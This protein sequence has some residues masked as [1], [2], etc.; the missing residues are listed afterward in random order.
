[1][2]G[3]DKD[4]FMKFKNKEM[5]YDQLKTRL[6]ERRYNFTYKCLDDLKPTIDESFYT[7]LQKF[8]PYF[9]MIYSKNPTY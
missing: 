3:A 9:N 1:M 5:T 8:E 4:L 2:R 6:A 7:N